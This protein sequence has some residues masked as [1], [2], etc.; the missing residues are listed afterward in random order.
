VPNNDPSGLGA[1]EFPLRFPGQ[2]FD[3]ET[4]LAYNVMRDYDPAIGRYVQSDP[5]GLVGGLNT[6]LYVNDSPTGY[7][8]ALGLQKKPGKIPKP[9]KNPLDDLPDKLCDYWP[10]KC[11][12]DSIICLEA[13]CTRIDCNGNKYTYTVY[14]WIPNNPPA[15]DPGKDCVCTRRTGTKD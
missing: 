5:I 11:V 14:N 15:N 10:A 9:G 13:V 3:R 8:D 2:Y 6:Y 1:F 12:P 7:T 4:N